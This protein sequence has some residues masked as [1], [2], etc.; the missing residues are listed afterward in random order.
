MESGVVKYD[1]I[2]PAFNCHFNFDISV[3]FNNFNFKANKNLHFLKID[4]EIFIDIQA[5]PSF[6]K[7][8]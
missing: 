2:L 8:N 6:N 1:L 7:N 5:K 4:D 3:K